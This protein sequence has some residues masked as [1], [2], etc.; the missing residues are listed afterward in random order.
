MRVAAALTLLI[1][2]LFAANATTTTVARSEI[3]QPPAGHAG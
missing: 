1:I 3:L 2:A